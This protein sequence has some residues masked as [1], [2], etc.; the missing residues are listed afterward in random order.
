M[1]QASACMGVQNAKAQTKYQSL[2]KRDQRV[3]KRVISRNEDSTCRQRVKREI[4]VQILKL[5]KVWKE[6]G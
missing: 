2:G 1:K 5:S 3:G 4:E 6:D